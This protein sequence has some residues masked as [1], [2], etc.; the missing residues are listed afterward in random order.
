MHNTLYE[1]TKSP[2]KSYYLIIYSLKFLTYNAIILSFLSDIFF[3]YIYKGDITIF[4]F[5]LTLIICNTIFCFIGDLILCYIESN[6][7]FSLKYLIYIYINRIAKAFLYTIIEKQYL[8][9]LSI[10]P[11]TIL[12]SLHN[13][14]SL[15]QN[16]VFFI[17]LRYFSYRVI[18]PISLMGEIFSIRKMDHHSNF[19][20]LFL[21]LYLIL[22]FIL[23]LFDNYKVSERMYNDY[24][25]IYQMK[26][27]RKEEFI[28]K[29]DQ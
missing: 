13:Y 29:K 5:S 19:F 22:F 15:T 25:K 3:K 18:L 8:L 11:W 20:K 24:A 28:K 10:L 21:Y 1:L 12:E 23:E 4:S 27:R 7:E 16:S 14:V 17:N 26:N 2:S 9:I 6:K